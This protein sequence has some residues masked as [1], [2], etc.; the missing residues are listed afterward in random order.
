V[1]P[2]RALALRLAALLHDA[3]YRKYFASD[4]AA[5]PLAN[6][7]AIMAEC[8]VPPAVAAVALRSIGW[9]SC[10]ANCNSVPDECAAA[11]ELLWPRWADRLEAVGVRGAVRSYRFVVVR[12][13]PFAVADTPHPA[14]AE[15]ALALAI[16]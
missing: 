8:A 11:P 9:V 1:P 3:D 13:Y 15:E 6:A 10:S 4:P 5:P 7:A 16:S 12:G 2:H 14:S